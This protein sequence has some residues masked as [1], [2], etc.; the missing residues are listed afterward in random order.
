MSN[1]QSQ[2]P[3]PVTRFPLTEAQ[4]ELWLLSQVSHEANCAFNECCSISLKGDLDVEALTK[5]LHQ[6]VKRNEMLR[7]TV[8]RDGQHVHIHDELDPGIHREDWSGLSKKEQEDA[9]KDA[10]KEESATPFDL[11]NGPLVR[12]RIQRIANDEHL[13]TLTAHHIVMDGWSLWV[14]CRDLGNL[15]SAVA[16]GTSADLPEVDR[17]EE[18]AAEMAEYHDSDE[19]K[20]DEAFWVDQ[21]SESIPVLDLPTDRP[22]PSLKTF[23]AS[24]VD[25]VIDA[26]LIG[27]LRKTGGKHGCSLF[28][29][30]LAGFQA[31]LA[32]ISQQDDVVVGIPTAGQAAT[33]RQNLIG[34]CVNSIPFRQAVDVA[35]PMLEF[36]KQVRTAMFD[37]LDHQKYT[38][39]TMLKKIAPPRDPSRPPIFSLM[40]NVDPAIN[41]DDIGFDGLNVELFIEPRSFENFEWFI[42]GVINADGSVEL[43]C[44]YNTNLFDAD[45]IANRLENYEALLR[46][47]IANPEKP[48]CELDLLSKSQKQRQIVDWN[49]TELGYPQDSTVYREFEAQAGRTPDSVAVVFGDSRLTF[50][51]LNARSN[52]FA[53]YLQEN[54]VG[55]GDLVGICLE[56]S[57]Q[58]LVALLGI[59]KTGA[60]YVPLDPGYPDDRLAYMCEQSGLKLLVSHSSLAEKVGQFNKPFLKIDSDC[61]AI[62]RQSTDSLE[63]D[64]EPADTAYVIYTSG[65][66]GKPKGV[67]VPHG[68]AVNFLYGMREQPGFDATDS[69]L[70][71]TTLSFDIAVLELYLPLLFGGKVIIA[72]AETASDGFK[73][74]EA[75][76]EH[77]ITFLQATPATWRLLIASGWEGK[78]VKALCGGEPMPVDLV[79]PLL[80]RVAELW[81]MYGPTET[82]VWSSVFRIV[83]A[84][85][86]IL[87]G[88]PIANTQLYLF[89]ANLESVPTGVPGEVFI[90]GA[91]VT[92]GYLHR[93][94]LTE[95][96]FVDNP[97]FNPFA[98]YVSSKVYKTGD[99]ARYRNDGNVEFLRRN[100]KQ[101]KVRG[102]RIE[103]GEIEQILTSHEAIAQGVVI[104]R[105]DVA[106][107]ARLVAYHVTA[108]GQF[109]TASDLRKHLRDSLPHYMIPQHF[110]ELDCFPQTN[111]GK[112]DYRAL[113]APEG[114]ATETVDFVPPDSASEVFLASL[115]QEKLNAEQ[116]GVNDNFFN[117]GGHSLLVMQVISQIE[118]EYGVRLSPQDFLMGTLEQIAAKLDDEIE[119]AS[120]GDGGTQ[121]GVSIPPLDN[122]APEA[123][124]MG[125]FRSLWN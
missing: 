68:A 73:L 5:A 50:A 90:G 76:N 33:D 71:V 85:A 96:R 89:D 56:R 101:V 79:E 80:K 102:Y 16:N 61:E 118:Q 38:F 72:D 82:T 2:S 91:G 8:D 58:L 60:G 52:Q 63:V 13:V 120:A 20:A 4:Q 59:W 24:R 114:T 48:I 122:G 64:G 62:D 104:V 3:N 70:A 25:R 111:N 41:C 11:E 6:T 67:N 21:F 99:L 14:F 42:N 77:D 29:V 74:I 18:Y 92:H 44:Q 19:G 26:D 88:K 81:N 30:M 123:G 75:I 15:Y 94:D 53:R 27:D 47:F 43:Q 17:Y 57:E 119:R 46:D 97:F 1:S 37:T 121:D 28:N 100:D 10:V 78:P 55:R 45:T 95:E 9:R 103:L 22:R 69:V 115:W 35:R 86:P 36:A 110:V 124:L 51:E 116:V 66:T 84:D 34:H 49:Q 107:D 54:N 117:I 83:D 106:G 32:R 105:E 40:F 7:A 39:G 125:R 65:S 112:I 23:D 87:I 31:F 113:P 98:D 108:D 93:D 12:L 109:V